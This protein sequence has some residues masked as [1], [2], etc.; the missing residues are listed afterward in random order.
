[1]SNETRVAVV[2]GSGRGIGKGIAEQLAHDGYA[3]VIA[4]FDAT[5]AKA[6]ADE[7]VAAGYQAV[8]VQG[9]VHR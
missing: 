3:V 1:M 6:T 8:A 7:L 4:D 9:D 5:T 2:T